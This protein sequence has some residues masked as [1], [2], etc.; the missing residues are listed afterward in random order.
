MSV[1]G[2]NGDQYLFGEWLAASR[3]EVHLLGASIGAWRMST[4]CLAHRPAGGV[5]LL[6]QLHL[7][8]QRLAGRDVAG[9]DLVAQVVRDLLVLLRAAERAGGQLRHVRDHVL[10]RQPGM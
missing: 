5:E 1:E 3:Q 8:G 4:A 7:A 9:E 10:L 2:A 6:A